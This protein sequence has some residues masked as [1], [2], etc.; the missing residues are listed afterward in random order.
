MIDL[1]TTYMGIPLKN[2]IVPSA[3]PLSAELDMIKR[4]ED[5]GAAAVT[6]PSLFEEQVEFEAESLA[7]FLELGTY[8][9]AEAL[10]YFPPLKEFRR[11]PKEY[12]E[13]IRK[14]SQAVGIPIIA[15]LNGISPGGWTSYARQFQEAGAAAVELNTYFLPT[16][17]QLTGDEVE[18]LYMSIVED[19]KQYVTIPI[20]VKIGPFFSSLPNIATRLDAAGANALVLFNRFYQP[21]LDIE[22]LDVQPHLVLSTSDEMRLPLRW[23]AILYGQVK[24]SLALTTGIH[25]SE[26]VLKAVMAGA[27]VANV[28]SALLQE[29]VGKIDALLHGI[30]TWMEQHEY[31]SI[32]EMKGSLSLRSVPE[33]A[34]FERANYMKVLKSYK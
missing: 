34:A 13:H 24:A 4:M 30:T 19:I 7:Y 28:C 32:S 3:S 15:S 29:G 33:P 12:V 9:Y 6:L 18:Q 20:A 10:T 17:S 14:A 21:D 2:P 22:C 23:I 26:D 27:D 1:S 8:S 25:T 16:R 11:G 31:K 5:A